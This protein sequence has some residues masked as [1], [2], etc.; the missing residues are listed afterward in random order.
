[1]KNKAW[2][3]RSKILIS[4]LSC[5]LTAIVLQFVFFL[6][7]SSH[8]IYNQAQEI[9]LNTLQNLQEDVYSYSKEYENSLIKIY[10]QKSFIHALALEEPSDQLRQ[11]YGQISYD[12]VQN[13]F[14]P[15]QYI[16]ALYLYTIDHRLISS[17]RHAQ[18]QKYSYPQDIFDGTMK[19]NEA[20]VKNYVASSNRIMLISSYYNTRQETN[21]VR[22][23]LKIYSPTEKSVGYL[24]CDVDSKALMMLLQK[25]RYSNGQILWLQPDEDR[26]MLSTDGLDGSQKAEFAQM[27]Q[28]ISEKGWQTN[29]AKFNGGKLFRTTLHKYNLAA[30]S[31]MPQQALLQ[32]QNALTRS[33]IFVVLV[34]LAVFTL[35]FLMISRGLTQPLTY[36]VRVMKQIKNGETKL[37]LKKMKQD[38]IGILGKEFN[39]MLDHIEVLIANEYQAKL[40]ADD[41]KYK[42]LQAQVNPHFLYNTLDTMSGIA[43]SQN[44]HTVHLLCQALSNIFRYS[45][46]MHSPYAKLEDEILHIKNYM[47]V[48]NVRLQN[49]IRVKISIDRE[50]LQEKVPRLS[51]QPLVEN[52]IQHGLKNKRGEKQIRII[53]YLHDNKLYVAVEDNGV[54]MDETKI[55]SQLEN[56][57]T[58]VLQKGTSIGIDN[59]NARVKLLFG[60]NYGV[61]VNSELGKGSQVVLSLP[62]IGDGLQRNE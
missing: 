60:Q 15:T 40:L 30:Y 17:Y 9:S 13:D 7:S 33:M 27:T 18:T 32:N 56:S 10:N 53:A 57:V 49:S 37:R 44:C 8:V 54:G 35:L 1:M 6:N 59:I 22:F 46:D 58:E 19:N 55:N 11:D 38:E 25:Y 29:I 61:H 2:S 16:D 52:A 5:I 28:Q 42:A 20:A 21:L 36:M 43:V 31:L 14:S 45:L 34:I 23:V 39:E 47:Y 12:M 48:I 26:V 62:H 4:C 24:V 41:A 3:M 51:L 50:L